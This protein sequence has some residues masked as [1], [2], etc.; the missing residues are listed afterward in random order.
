MPLIL[1]ATVILYRYFQ[2][3]GGYL[4][5]PLCDRKDGKKD[6]N[7]FGTGETFLFSLEPT[8]DVFPWTEI[9]QVDG[10]SPKLNT[11][12]TS[13]V[14]VDIKSTTNRRRRSFKLTKRKVSL[15]L[16]GIPKNFSF[17]N[18]VAS[19][20]SYGGIR[21]NSSMD[22]FNKYP[23]DGS[24]Q[25]SPMGNMRGVPAK[26]DNSTLSASNL[27]PVFAEMSPDPHDKDAPNNKHHQSQSKDTHEHS[28][29]ENQADSMVDDVDA[30]DSRRITRL[31]DESIC[32]VE[33]RLQLD[34]SDGKQ[35]P[36][37]VQ[38]TKKAPND[39]FIA[40]NDRCLIIGGG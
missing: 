38:H 18:D 21:K 33:K 30:D 8:L 39:L 19:T 40:G 35:P 7:Y 2:I 28:P 36:G 24:D 5:K 27:P 10:K 1:C 4:S 22:H 13:F 20:K 25:D 16:Q 11:R 3:F 14:V 6:L 17:A 29:P 37:H 31:P 34:D 32:L 15:K 26:L 23:N 9:V 12:N